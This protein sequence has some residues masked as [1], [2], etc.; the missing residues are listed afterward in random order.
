[1]VRSELVRL[2]HPAEIGVVIVREVRSVRP[3]M[4]RMKKLY[5]R[6]PAQLWITNEARNVLLSHYV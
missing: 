5:L 6:V 4:G 2:S 3:V 1:M